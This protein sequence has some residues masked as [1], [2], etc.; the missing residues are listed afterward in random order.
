MSKLILPGRK[1]KEREQAYAWELFK[2]RWIDAIRSGTQGFDA[3]A[4]YRECMAVAIMVATVETESVGE[5]S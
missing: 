5:R 2:E 4:A 3:E 1:L